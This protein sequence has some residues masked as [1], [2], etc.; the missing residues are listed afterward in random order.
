VTLEPDADERQ[1][2][3]V[4]AY[5]VVSEALANVAKAARRRMPRWWCGG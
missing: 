1:L 4:E 5:L 3:P 2:G